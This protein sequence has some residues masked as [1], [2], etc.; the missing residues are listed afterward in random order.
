MRGD[1]DGYLA[2]FNPAHADLQDL[3][4]GVQEREG[5]GGTIGNGRITLDPAKRL[6]MYKEAQKELLH[7]PAADPAR[8]VKK[9]QVVRKRVQDM[10]VAFSDFNT[11][12]RN[13]CG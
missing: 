2:E 6:P 7:G 9:Y 8:R 13:T 5:R 11:G 1:V 12:L 10:Y 3:V 4:P